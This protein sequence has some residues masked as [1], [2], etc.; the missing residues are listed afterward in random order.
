M[1]RNYMPPPTEEPITSSTTP[2]PPPSPS[3][4]PRMTESE[5]SDAATS[6]PASTTT[7]INSTPTPTPTPTSPSPQPL[8]PTVPP[9]NSEPSTPSPKDPMTLLLT[10]SHAAAYIFT[11]AWS[12]HAPS[13]PLSNL[14]FYSP[15]L[16]LWAILFLTTSLLILFHSSSKNINIKKGRKK[17]AYIMSA[18]LGLVIGTSYQIFIQRRFQGENFG[19]FIFGVLAAVYLALGLEMW[20]GGIS[21]LEEW[22]MRER[23]GD[24]EGGGRD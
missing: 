24:L 3:D 7:T 6:C 23:E 18:I 8:P 11:G 21:R 22:L 12:Y 17:D 19:T 16:L 1:T 10:T 14:D 15:L 13:Q 5:S 2:P 20:V 4:T 9:P